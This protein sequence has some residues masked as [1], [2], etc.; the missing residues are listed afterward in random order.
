VKARIY[1]A[2]YGGYEEPK[3]LPA[4]TRGLLYADRPY[5]ARGW[6]YASARH[7]IVTRKGDP[8]LVAPMLAHKYWKCHPGEALPDA[9]ISMWVDASIRL[10]PGFFERAVEALGEDDWLLVR[11]PWRD[12]IYEEAAYSAA[13]PRYQSLSSDLK[14]QSAW[15]VSLGHPAKGGLPATGI[16]VRRHTPEVLEASRHWWFECLNW[17]HQDQVSLP[18]ILDMLKIK[19]R[20]GLEWMDG[21]ETFPHS[22]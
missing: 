20:Y 4:G 1:S 19:Y 15:Y 21:W 3:S 18:V 14:T 2:L 17:S 10:E 9:D 6:A 12:C 16:M 13:L 11:H 22:R 7:N 8:A 5:V